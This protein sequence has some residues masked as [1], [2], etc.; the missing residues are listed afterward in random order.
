MLEGPV[1]QFHGSVLLST[2][3]VP[4]RSS[5]DFAREVLG[6]RDIA[7]RSGPE[8]D[9]MTRLALLSLLCQQPRVSKM[10][11]FVSCLLT[12]GSGCR[13]DGGRN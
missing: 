4:H 1:N 6:I 2:S 8:I 5:G 13:V 11:V 10:A 12:G 3:F 7:P 9:D